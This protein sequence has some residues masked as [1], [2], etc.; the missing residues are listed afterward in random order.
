MKVFQECTGVLQV[1]D[2]PSVS[3]DYLKSLL[4]EIV[5]EKEEEASMDT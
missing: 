2:I 5:E 3:G 4:G 1:Q